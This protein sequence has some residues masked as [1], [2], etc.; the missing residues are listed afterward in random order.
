MYTTK[1]LERD[2]KVRFHQVTTIVSSRLSSTVFVQVKDFKK[3][4]E[5]LIEDDSHG[6]KEIREQG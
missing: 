1:I 5:T 2:L 6:G 4:N 3:K